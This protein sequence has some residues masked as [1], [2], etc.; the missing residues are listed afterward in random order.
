[1]NPSSPMFFSSTEISPFI[2]QDPSFPDKLLPVTANITTLP[3]NTVLSRPPP[4]IQVGR[5]PGPTLNPPAPPSLTALAID[6]QLEAFL[7]GTLKGETEPRTL[8]LMEELHSQL[9]EHSPHSPMDTDTT[10]FN[11]VSAPPSSY[12]LDHTNLDNMEWLDLTM[13][14][15]TEGLNPLGL[16]PSG[17]FSSDFLDSH[18]LQL[19]WD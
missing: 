11:N 6:N 5:P 17:V 3:F 18:D 12:H 14:G 10:G 1:M 16:P 13:P 15:P 19:H 4:Q 2:R 7:E 9:L 8:R